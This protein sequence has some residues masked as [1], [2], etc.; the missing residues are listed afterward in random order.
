[1]FNA[2]MFA[3]MKKGAIFVSSSRE[4]LVVE[5]DLA[6]AI[7]SGQPRLYFDATGCS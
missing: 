6:A 1:M 7:K 2:A 3:R 4:Q 5:P